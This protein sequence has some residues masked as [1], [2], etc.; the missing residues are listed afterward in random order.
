M[1]NMG[2]FL[3]HNTGLVY[4]GAGIYFVVALAPGAWLLF[5]RQRQ[6]DQ[7]YHACPTCIPA[8]ANTPEQRR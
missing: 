5:S 7:E 2:S 6:S 4:A 1:S 3:S 8:D